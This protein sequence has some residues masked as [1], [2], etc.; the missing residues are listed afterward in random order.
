MPAFAS[1]SIASALSVA[2][3]NLCADEYLLT[4]AKPSE[5]ASVTFLA[6][7]P[8][9]SPLW[10]QARRYPANR[11]SIE[12]VIAL[13]PDIILT[14][15]GGGKAT[16]LLA[17][18]LGV[19]VVH[20]PFPASIADVA[21]NMRRVASALGRPRAA[22]RWIARVAM[23]RTSS[24][25]RRADALFVGHGG[26]SLVGGSPATEWMTLA[27]LQQRQLSSGKITLEALAIRPPAVLLRSEYRAGQMSAGARWFDH[28]IVR[29][30]EGRTIRTD[31]RRWTCAGPL[32][33]D[34]ILRLRKALP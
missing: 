25:R 4:L 13:K 21:S 31:G 24:P 28:P 1:L 34:E 26:N 27:G 23:L 18:K 15:G 10:R 17:D 33:V 19:R 3:L 6:R 5:V 20:L 22:D 12:D 29:R 16:K 8:D 2:S 14:M 11:G 32:M 30:L 7:D 9:E